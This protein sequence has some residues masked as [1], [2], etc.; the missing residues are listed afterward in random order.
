MH[1]PA[2]QINDRL[3]RQVEALL[4]QSPFDHVVVVA[5][6]IDQRLQRIGIL[7]DP[8]QLGRAV[9]DLS[10]N[11][12]QRFDRVRLLAHK[13][14]S[15]AGGIH[16]EP[17][18]AIVK[19]FN[20][21]DDAIL[22]PLQV[23]RLVMHDAVPPV[24]QI[25][26]GAIVKGG[27]SEQREDRLL[28]DLALVSPELG[29]ELLESLQL[30]DAQG[31]IFITLDLPE[32]EDA[33][34]EVS[35]LVGLLPRAVHTHRS[36]LTTP[37][38]EGEKIC[39]VHL[40]EEDT[41]KQYRDRVPVASVDLELNRVGAFVIAKQREVVLDRSSIGFRNKL[42]QTLATD[43]RL[44]FSEDVMYPAK[45]PGDRT[46]LVELQEGVAKGKSEA[47]KHLGIST[48]VNHG[49]NIPRSYEC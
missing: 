41:R 30:D 16:L 10:Q 8:H 39:V 13:R 33:L 27:T 49:R 4:A 44:G 9:L 43:R 24:A 5:C 2:L 38:S 6:L 3:K 48:T 17:S 7:E 12:G 32:R 25:G 36:L 47:C 15:Q 21:T 29:L 1:R 19:S 42:Q 40:F 34:G 26:D 46:L 31:R 11:A 22:E 18:P 20:R 28:K 45:S 35:A 37:F 14:N 23:E